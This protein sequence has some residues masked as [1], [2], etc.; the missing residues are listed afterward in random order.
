MFGLGD[1]SIFSGLSKAALTHVEAAGTL[2]VIPKNTLVVSEGAYADSFYVIRSGRVKIFVTGINGRE[3][4]LREQWAREYFGELALFDSGLRSA[5]VETME[6]T[7]LWI[8][9][10]ASFLKLIEQYPS[11]TAQL[12]R[13]LAFR[14]RALTGSVKNLALLDVYGRVSRLLREVGREQADG[15]YLIE[16]KLT[17]QGIADRVGASRERVAR[18]LKELKQGGYLQH[19]TEGMIVAKHLPLIG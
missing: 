11:I 1:I 12:L 16:T 6:K 2:R 4:V 7:S 18:V 3:V 5:T 17:Q 14:V 10:R 8:F 13:E 15:S 19:A 9:T